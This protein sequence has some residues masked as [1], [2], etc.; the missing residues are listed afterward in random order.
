MGQQIAYRLLLAIPVLLGVA[1]LGFLLIKLV[2]G[3]PAMVIAGPMATPD[4]VEAI[5]SEMGLDQP[6]IVQLWRYLVR[7]AHLDL[8]KSMINN[9]SVAAELAGAVAATAELMI[10]C[11]A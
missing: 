5:R 1:V 6:I 4:V 11:L 7:L 8:G 3:D 10:A 2:P 9:T